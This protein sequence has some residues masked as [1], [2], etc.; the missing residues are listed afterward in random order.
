M[1]RKIITLLVC[2]I[3]LSSCAAVLPL[4]VAGTAVV[5]SD[6]RSI[7]VIID[8][9]MIASK[10]K[11]ELS[12]KGNGHMFLS[13]H[14]TVLEGRVMLTGSV[15]SS[16]C[17]DEAVKIAWSTKGVK[18]VI[19]EVVVELKNLQHSANDTLIEKAIESRLLVEKNLVSN[20][21]KISVNDNIVFIL[22]IAQSQEEMQKALHIASNAKG[23]SKVVN[24][25]ILKND[26]RRGVN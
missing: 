15:A 7:G 22:G 26:P 21:Y 8:D 14:V 5:L 9:Q 25:I 13:I 24:Y 4:S 20:N 11:G 23:V 19:N 3:A 16:E 2:Q 17:I 10:I 1:S 6:Q 18:E 12:R